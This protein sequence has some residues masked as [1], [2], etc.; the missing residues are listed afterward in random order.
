[1][2]TRMTCLALGTLLSGAPGAFAL[3]PTAAD[4]ASPDIGFVVDAG[5]LE[6]DS[7]AEG[8][9]LDP[10]LAEEAPPA[11]PPSL[12][13]SAASAE[14]QAP[15]TARPVAFE[16]S[17]GYYKRLKVHKIASFATLPLFITQFVL[18]QKLLVM[19]Y[20]NLRHLQENHY[21]TASLF[22]V[23]RCVQLRRESVRKFEGLG[24]M[25][26]QAVAAMRKIWE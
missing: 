2:K 12:A 8:S 11:A 3:G 5:D 14:P 18:G 22:M 19:I 23:K 20:L 7:L 1:M 21:Q 17:D 26:G 25:V 16:Y 13:A 6:E 10:S 15:S 4:L 9:C 24:G